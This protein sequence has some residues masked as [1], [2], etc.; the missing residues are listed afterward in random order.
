M[1]LARVLEVEREVRIGEVRALLHHVEE[2]AGE[3][4][5]HSHAYVNVPVQLIPRIEVGF[6]PDVVS[7]R[8]SAITNDGAARRVVERIGGA[9]EPEIQPLAGEGPSVVRFDGDAGAN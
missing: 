2:L 8:A 9:G 1:R 7:G 4:V 5:P 6:L 3:D